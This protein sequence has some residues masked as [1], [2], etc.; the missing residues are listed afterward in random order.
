MA[1]NKNSILVNRTCSLSGVTIYQRCGKTVLR[2][3][4]NNAHKKSRTIGQQNQRI[5]FANC[6]VLAQMMPEDGVF[7]FSDRPE[8]CS[9][10]NAFIHHNASLCNVFLPRDMSRI[11]QS[12][13]FDG[14]VVS[15]GT[16][17]TIGINGYTA[18]GLLVTTLSL[19]NMEIG[20][21][22]TLAQLTNA[23]VENNSD[24]YE[25]DELVIVTCW[26]RYIEE[27]FTQFGACILPLDGADRR[28]LTNLAGSRLLRSLTGITG[29]QVLALDTAAVPYCAGLAV[30]L[31]RRAGNGERASPAKLHLLPGFADR[32]TGREAFERAAASYGGIT[33][34]GMLE[35]DFGKETLR[36]A[37]KKL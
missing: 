19:G 4:K 32:Y 31:R 7:C 13:P 36:G 14:M 28:N 8:G 30:Y 22:T 16:L 20:D 17:S 3:S 26:V 21:D 9:A 2:P 35:P 1:N 27:P 18:D 34:P 25:H 6:V 11:K 5:R 37:F 24:T 12:M 23:V 29:Q 15:S 33:A 10:Y